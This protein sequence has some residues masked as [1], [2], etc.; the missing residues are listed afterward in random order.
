MPTS[1]ALG[2][3][4]LTTGPPGKTLVLTCISLM[5]YDVEHRLI[6]LLVFCLSS[7]DE[8]S[9]EVFGPFFNWVVCFL[10]EF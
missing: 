4:F 5:E 6:C 3:G 9:I 2:G 10:V 7:I 8:V 1:P